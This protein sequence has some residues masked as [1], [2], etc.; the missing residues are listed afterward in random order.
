MKF[1]IKKEQKVYSGFLKVLKAEVTHD[2]FKDKETITASR[3]CL[4]R[5]DSVA[6]LIYEKETDSFLFTRQFRYPSARRDSPWILELVA[7]SVDENEE[8]ETAAKREV[9][10]E[11]GFKIDHLEKIVTYFPSPGGCSEQISLFYTEVN[12][13][14]QTQEEGGKKEE[15]EDIELVRFKKDVAKKMLQEGAFNNSITIIGLQ[16]W[17]LNQL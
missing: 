10:E 2:T 8:A 16:W 3:E 14:Q 4:E 11:I 5:G 17:F 15:K 7:G 9:Q 1:D 13:K 12:S 6:V